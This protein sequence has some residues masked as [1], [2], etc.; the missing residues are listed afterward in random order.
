[1]EHLEKIDEWKEICEKHHALLIEDAAESFG[2]TY[3]GEQT[4]V[5]EIIMQFPSMEIRSSPALP[6]ECF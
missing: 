4:G 6:E 1:M 2:A 5:F 3:K